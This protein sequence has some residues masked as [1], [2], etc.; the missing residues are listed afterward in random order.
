MLE[1]LTHHTGQLIL[2]SDIEGYLI[3]ILSIDDVEIGLNDIINC[4]LHLVVALKSSQY[5]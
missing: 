1:V 5:R 2:K 4:L 3:Q